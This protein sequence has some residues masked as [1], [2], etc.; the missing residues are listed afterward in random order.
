[1]RI[2]ELSPGECESASAGLAEVKVDCVDDGA[3]VG[4]LAPLGMETGDGLV[5][6]GGSST[7]RADLGR[8]VR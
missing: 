2:E 7:R 4:F 3:S 1:M 5:A 6:R 8:A